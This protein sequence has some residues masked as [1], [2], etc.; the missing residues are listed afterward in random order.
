MNF[1]IF[2]IKLLDIAKF[3]EEKKKKFMEIFYQYYYARLI[4]E[5]AG[6]DP[7]YAQR[8][9]AAV[10]NLKIKPEQFKTLL[11]E[12]LATPEFSAKINEVTDEVIGY[13]VEDV[14][15]SANEVQRAQILSAVS[16]S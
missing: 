2:L 11:T 4:D 7:S 14:K 9:A 1:Q 12:L 5:F 8:L 6:I 13:L 3:S 16:A 15:K 10:D